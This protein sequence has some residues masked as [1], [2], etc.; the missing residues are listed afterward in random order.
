[1]ANGWV[2]RFGCAV[3][4][5]A[6]LVTGCTSGAG[7]Q[8]ATPPPQARATGSAAP[9]PSTAVDIDPG[10]LPTTAARATALIR[11]VI[12]QPAA[13]GPDTER[14]TPYESDP[15]RWA[16][17]RKNCV[18][19]QQALPKDV[20]AT[21]TRHYEVPA[22]GGKGPILL[23]AVVT[24][25]RTAEQADWENAE[26]LEEMMR[27][28]SQLLR[29]GEVLSNLTDVP[30]A[31]GD[32]GITYADDVLT[33]MGEYTSDEAGGPH[34]YVWSQT[35][36]G[37]FTVAVSAKGSKGWSRTDLFDRLRQPH[38]DMRGR[39]AGAIERGTA[40]A[41]PSAS[42]STTAKDTR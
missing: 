6:L 1:M 4:T 32:D 27:C 14:D 15:R 5:G 37:P 2:V 24:A 9:S 42:A 18:W 36:I 23:T 40:A 35:R 25:H 20:L 8:A 34:A 26:V 17:L 12:A 39:L 21:L 31:L 11:D 29:A 41:S 19:E 22:G 28:P 3:A 30:T 10:K 13:F 38:A 16:V 33:E 7:E